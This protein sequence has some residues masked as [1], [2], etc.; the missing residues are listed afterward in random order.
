MVKRRTEFLTGAVCYFG[1][2][3]VLSAISFL[4]DFAVPV[5]VDAA[6]RWP[7]MHASVVEVIVPPADIR[8]R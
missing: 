3:G 4:G 8:Q 6:P 1:I 5:K 7:L 2:A